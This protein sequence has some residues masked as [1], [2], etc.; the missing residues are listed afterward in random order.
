MAIAAMMERMTLHPIN[1]TNAI[2]SGPVMT[3]IIIKVR[4]ILPSFL[5]S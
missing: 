4:S 1:A 3:S 2:I 5:I